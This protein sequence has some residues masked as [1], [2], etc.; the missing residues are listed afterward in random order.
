MYIWRRG[1]VG[2]VFIGLGIKGR[3]WEGDVGVGWDN[4]VCDEVGV[5]GAL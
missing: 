4:F 1:D 3:G 2:V 5:M